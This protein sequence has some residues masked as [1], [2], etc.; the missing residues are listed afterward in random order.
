MQ[1]YAANHL[2]ENIAMTT[3]D[4]IFY[5]TLKA[6]GCLWP[7]VHL[8]GLVLCVLTY[9]R[10]RKSG[11]LVVAAYYFLAV[12]WLAFGPAINRVIREYSHSQSPH[13]LSPE[14]QKQ[15]M[16]DLAALNEKYY[17]MGRP[18]ISNTKFP[19]GPIILVSGLWCIARRESKRTTEHVDRP[20]T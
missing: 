3:S 6:I 1:R 15:Y 8:F 19:L 7:L 10:C 17:P 12:G 5:I 9:R 18:A 4:W 16:Q 13:V 2:L 11:Y 20:Q 14:T